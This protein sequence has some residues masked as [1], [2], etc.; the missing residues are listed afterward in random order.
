MTNG[1]LSINQSINQ[2]NHQ[3]I[4]QSITTSSRISPTSHTQ[5]P[6]NSRMTM[7]SAAANGAR[8]K[9]P[10]STHSHNSHR[11]RTRRTNC[12]SCNSQLPRETQSILH[13]CMQRPNADLRTP[14]LA[15]PPSQPIKPD[16]RARTSIHVGP[17]PVLSV[18]RFPKSWLATLQASKRAGRRRSHRFST[19]HTQHSN[20]RI[21][22]PSWIFFIAETIDLT[23][24]R[25]VTGFHQSST[26]SLARAPASL[27]PFL[28]AYIVHAHMRTS[29]LST[30]KPPVATAVVNNDTQ[31]PQKIKRDSESRQ[32]KT[33]QQASWRAT[34]AAPK[35]QQTFLSCMR[36][37]DLPAG[38]SG[39]A[40][41]GS[42]VRCGGYNWA[43]KE[44]QMS[45]NFARANRFFA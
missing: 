26:Y 24:R 23:R 2:S 42:R 16:R 12:N 25:H 44:R 27:L 39:R 34:T 22:I 35:P 1:K 21:R 31:P 43:Y 15:F 45:N 30:T 38:C 13:K 19:P 37:R 3:P 17:A 33:K 36:S 29:G 6:C 41:R 18:V 20:T 5:A 11:R 9:L 4:N 7:G 14:A 8:P 32:S 40:A 10:P 28:R